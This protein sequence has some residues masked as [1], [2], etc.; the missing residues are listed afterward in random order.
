MSILKVARLGHPIIR[1]KSESVNADEIPSAACQQFIQDM[2]HTMHEYDGVGLAAPQVHIAKQIAVIEVQQ[3]PRYPEMPHV[4]LTVLINPKIISHSKKIEEAWEGCLS[5]PD[6]RGIVP[7]YEEVV[8]EAY[9]LEGK[10]IKIE[11]KGFF[12]RI[13][14][15]ELDHL[16]GHV[17]VDQMTD[18]KSLSYLEEFARFAH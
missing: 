11:A 16:I 6:M 3:N 10:K 15:H 9:D 12:A 5:I 17:Y 13:I 18:L 1:S 7:R 2:I 4:P 8:C 14:Q